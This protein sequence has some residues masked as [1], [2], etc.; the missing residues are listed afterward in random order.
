[1]SEQ[2][3]LLIVGAIC[4]G[5]GLIWVW[6]GDKEIPLK[7]GAILRALSRPP[8]HMRRMKWLMGGGLILGGA[9]F[10]KRGLE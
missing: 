2:A 9:M 5:I 1:V 8:G 4:I 6:V 10:I 7:G 3:V